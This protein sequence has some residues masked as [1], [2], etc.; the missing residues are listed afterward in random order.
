MERSTSTICLAAP[1]YGGDPIAAVN[2]VG[3]V[4]RFTGLRPVNPAGSRAVWGSNFSCQ[5]HEEDEILVA[6]SRSDSSDALEFFGVSS[7]EGWEAK[8]EATPSRSVKRKCSTPA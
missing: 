5:G 3:S 1:T 6:E 7:P 8:W 2:R 4:G